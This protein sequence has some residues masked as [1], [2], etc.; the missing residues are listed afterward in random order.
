MLF[1]IVLIGLSLWLLWRWLL[2]ILRKEIGKFAPPP[3][4]PAPDK[5]TPNQIQE[6]TACPVCG[7]WSPQNAPNRCGRPDCPF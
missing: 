5:S 7:V 1:R 3:Q 2:S 4:P 6:L